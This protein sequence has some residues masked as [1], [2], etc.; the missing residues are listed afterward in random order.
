MT[1]FFEIIYF[2]R[3]L[4]YRHRRDINNVPR[5]RSQSCNSDNRSDLLRA[6]LDSMADRAACY[7]FDGRHTPFAIGQRDVDDL[8]SRLDNCSIVLARD[9]TRSG[10]SD[11][12]LDLLVTSLGDFQ[13]TILD[14]CLLI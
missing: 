1:C 5:L 14:R 12:L 4:G 3:R 10:L 13:A 6:M 8:A 2:W 9:S 7:V 11:Q